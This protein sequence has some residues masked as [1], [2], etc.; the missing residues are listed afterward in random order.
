MLYGYYLV[1]FVLQSG[2]RH[3]DSSFMSAY[4]V[5]LEQYKQM[6]PILVHQSL[7]VPAVMFDERDGI[8]ICEAVVFVE[9]GRSGLLLSRSWGDTGSGSWGSRR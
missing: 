6:L 1:V 4:H 3:L 9:R 5:M 8:F 2:Q 7:V